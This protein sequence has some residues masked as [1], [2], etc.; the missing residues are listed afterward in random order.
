MEISLNRVLSRMHDIRIDSAGPL[1]HQ[2]K[3]VVRSLHELPLT[4]TGTN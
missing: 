3:V 2:H 1:K 4:F